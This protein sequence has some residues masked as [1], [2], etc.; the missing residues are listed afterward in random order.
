MRKPALALAA[1]GAV[2]GLAG[3]GPGQDSSP[4]PSAGPSSGGAVR[5]GSR[6]MRISASFARGWFGPDLPGY[7]EVEGTYGSFE[8]AALPP[9]E[10][11]T[12]GTLAW[13]A[14]L[15]APIRRI[16]ERYW[17]S[18]P[19][20]SKL[21]ANFER[22]VAEAAKR[23]YALPKTFLSFLRRAQVSLTIPCPALL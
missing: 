9:L 11:K 19:E 2:W 21:E 12:G 14:P 1:A 20:R 5:E 15:D 16:M 4:A 6:P 7:R 10:E 8:Y 3:R 18:D 23:G 22:I 17:S 13:L